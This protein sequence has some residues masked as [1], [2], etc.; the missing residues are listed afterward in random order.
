MIARLLCGIAALLICVGS[1]AQGAKEDSDS[2][3][4]EA[5]TI[6]VPDIPFPE[7]PAATALSRDADPVLRPST[8]REFAASVNGLVDR[9]GRI[10]KGVSITITPMAFAVRE[11]KGYQEGSFTQIYQ[12]TQFSIATVL[13]D[14]ADGKSNNG[15]RL[16]LGIRIPIFD[17][18]DPRTAT[19]EGTFRDC[20]GKFGKEVARTKQLKLTLP[21]QIELMKTEELE[22]LV[23]QLDALKKQAGASLTDGQKIGIS[24][25]AGDIEKKKEEIANLEADLVS[26]KDAQ[27]A[28]PKKLA[29]CAADHLN[30]SKS[31]PAFAPAFHVAFAQTW[32]DVGVDKADLRKD[33]RYL[34]LN[35]RG[36]VP[37]T[38][39]RYVL[40]A[41][42]TQNAIDPGTTPIAERIY[43]SSQAA[44]RYFAEQKDDWHL[45]LAGAYERRKFDASGKTSNVRT[46]L[47]GSDFKWAKDKWLRLTLG[48]ERKSDG[49]SQPT[50]NATFD[51]G[52]EAA[53]L[54]MDGK[55]M[56]GLV[57]LKSE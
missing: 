37:S 19:W 25:K 5:I 42:A 50:V 44:A 22:P 36:G 47:V 23:K 39:H 49:Q 38:K 55:E 31:D 56:K 1:V 12:N 29:A 2:K 24:A 6:A 3:K 41:R 53:P 15:Q 32:T 20:I 40:Q 43:D 7:S 10:A 52:F 26:Q 13:N 51:W 57:G 18:S 46:L 14:K 4:E 9:N 17:K 16:A 30:R 54:Q 48:R 45:S 28:V 34:W 21:G 35:F 11:P 33:A 8:A 27:A